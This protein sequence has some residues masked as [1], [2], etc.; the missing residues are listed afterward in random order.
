VPRGTDTYAPAVI[1][2]SF[3][4]IVTVPSPATT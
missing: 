1:G 2:M 3:V 4:F